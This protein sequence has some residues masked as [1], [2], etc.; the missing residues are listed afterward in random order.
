MGGEGGFANPKRIL[1]VYMTVTRQFI[2]MVS[3]SMIGVCGRGW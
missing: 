3:C 1:K 2:F